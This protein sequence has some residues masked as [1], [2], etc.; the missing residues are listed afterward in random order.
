MCRTAGP[1]YHPRNRPDQRRTTMSHART[2]PRTPATLLPPALLV[3][4]LVTGVVA[5]PAH[6]SP[7]EHGKEP[8]ATGTGGGGAPLGPSAS[9]AAEQLLAA[10]GSAGGAP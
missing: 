1:P 9:L 4:T 2:R 3:T 5:A 7:Q 10:R 8:T 6:G